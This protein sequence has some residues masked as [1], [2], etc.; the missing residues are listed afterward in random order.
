[1]KI[2]MKTEWG[3]PGGGVPSGQVVDVTEQKAVQ[4]VTGGFATYVGPVPDAEDLAEAMASEFDDIGRVDLRKMCIEKGLSAAGGKAKLISRLEAAKKAE[5]DSEDQDDE[6]D[7]DDQDDENAVT[8]PPEN[9][10]I[11]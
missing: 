11:R 8:G 1:M 4:L 3:R 10:A 6:S 5:S 9:T 7:S 2:K